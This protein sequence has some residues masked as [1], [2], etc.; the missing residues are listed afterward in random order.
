M[1]NQLIW[2]ENKTNKA[3][4]SSI[5]TIKVKGNDK[6]ENRRN[7]LFKR[8]LK[9]REKRRLKNRI[10]SYYESRK[11]SG[12]RVKLKKR[13]HFDPKV[14]Y[15]HDIEHFCNLNSANEFKKYRG[16]FQL[17]KDFSLHENPNKVLKTILRIL[18]NAKNSRN[19]AT[20]EYS[21]DV[22]FGALYLL[23]SACWEIASKRPKW[24]LRPKYI[25]KRNFEIQSRL[26]SFKTGDLD[27]DD[28]YIYNN[29][30]RINRE[31]DLQARQDHKEASKTVCDLINKGIES[32]IEVAHSLSHEENR[33][34][35]ATISEHFD[36]ILLH[37][38]NAKYGHLCTFF[39]RKKKTVT[40]LIFN[41]GHTIASSLQKTVIP[42][43]VRKNI[44]EVV[45]NHKQ[46][47]FFGLGSSFTEENALTLLAIQEGISSKLIDDETRGHGIIDY[48]RHSK[49]L[50]S[51]TKF[52]IISG[53]TAIKIDN[54][55]EI[56]RKKIFGR[57]RKILALN[58]EN[59]IMIKPNDNNVR[60]M[61]V[62]FPGVIIETIIPIKIS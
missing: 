13:K 38:P 45:K 19:F 42:E 33:A 20:V 47:G 48:I 37:V 29:K 53:K 11:Y 52:S 51:D 54:T 2:K 59:D 5:K 40:I 31:D 7:K 61:S 9:S 32:C 60:N 36:N 26:K 46:K 23:D 30:I 14:R 18:H 44:N 21:G 10:N 27:T 39:D 15:E 4:K 24:K 62:F 55:C 16:V 1:E 56:K 6:T 35:I 41:Y 58:K 28:A 49:N 17:T 50:S 43:E 3:F 22:S 57:E 8:K 25:S 12:N 34:I